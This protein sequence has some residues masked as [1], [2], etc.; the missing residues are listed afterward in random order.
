MEREPR[1]DRITVPE[2]NFTG[3]EAYDR[4][5]LRIGEVDDLFLDTNDRPEYIG[6]KIGVLG[7]Q[8][9]L[10]PL[11]GA[12]IDE[13]EGRI[14]VSADKDTVVDGP[15]FD[16][17]RE[18]T[19]EYEEQVRTYYGLDSF[20]GNEDRGTYG[21]YSGE[22]ASSAAAPDATGRGMR[23]GD[24]D[25]GASGLGETNLGETGSGGFREHGLGDE[26]VTDRPSS[27]LEHEGE[28]RAG[29]RDDR[30][31]ISLEDEED[32]RGGARRDRSGS[33]LGEDGVSDQT[34]SELEHGDETTIQ[35]SEEE[36]RVGTR[37]SEAKAVR[38]RKRVVTERQRMNTPRMR[39]EVTVERV[40]VEGRDAV[41]AEVEI[42]EDEIVVPVI[43][44]EIVVEKRP[45]VKEE[46]RI[47]KDVIHE[48]EAVE[49]E[50]RKE[51][52]EIDD[53]TTQ[54]DR[55]RQEHEIDDETTRRDHQRQE[56]P[57]ESRPRKEDRL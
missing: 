2:G 6:V 1:T 3:Y 52:I 48:E 35:R 31:G 20:A 53:H 4:N 45:V 22:E 16:D 10:I 42:G 33:G 11:D 50:V 12:T 15:T 55:P 40:P 51:E 47:R 7:T 19:P 13:E 24:Y 23:M 27:G 9:A 41:G 44:E 25:R 36:L 17:D 5:R 49:A 43:E 57:M 26:G 28:M 38:V 30:S 21:A 8:S 32:L 39:E 29:T 14:V 34:G 46:I 18:I 54:R 37:K 56:H